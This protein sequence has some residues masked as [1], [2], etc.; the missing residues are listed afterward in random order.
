MVLKHRSDPV[1][2][3]FPSLASQILHSPSNNP[4]AITKMTL[5]I[6]KMYLFLKEGTSLSAARKLSEKLSI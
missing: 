3:C 1:T 4:A 5:P 2:F 6:R